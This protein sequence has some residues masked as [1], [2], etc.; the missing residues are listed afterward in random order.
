MKKL[1]FVVTPL[2]G[3]NVETREIPLAGAKETG[4]PF[5]R[6]RL[7]VAMSSPDTVQIKVTDLG[8]GELFPANGQV[9]EKSFQVS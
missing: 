4:A 5:T 3:K 7:E 2:T 9:W 6:Y 8:F 1:E